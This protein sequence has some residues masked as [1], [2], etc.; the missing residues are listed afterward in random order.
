MPT[1]LDRYLGGER[2]EAWAE[3][4]AMGDEVR[5]EPILSDARA[6]ADETMRRARH[7]IETLLP[8]LGAVEYRF[9]LPMIESQIEWLTQRLGNGSALHQELKRD[10][11]A[12]WEAELKRIGT[13]PAL[14]DPKV[15]YPPEERATREALKSIGV[16]G[17]GP[18]PLSLEAWYRHVGYVSFEGTHEVLNPRGNLAADPLVVMP[19]DKLYAATCYA[20]DGKPAKLGMSPDAKQKAS[21]PRMPTIAQYHITLPN[22]GADWMY[23]DEWRDTTFVN[24]LRKAFEWAG[25]PGWEREATSPRETIAKLTEGLLPL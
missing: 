23:E 7:N 10:E 24:Y 1:F 12:K 20:L 21:P 22:A 14:K 19:V 3:L 11:K 2:V 8:R 4:V 6:V 9:G 17:K 18:V 13:K 15:F 5:K 16:R 25:F